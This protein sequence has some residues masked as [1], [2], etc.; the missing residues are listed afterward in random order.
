[1]DGWK[2]PEGY[3]ILTVRFVSQ[4]IRFG[5]RPDMGEWIEIE[6]LGKDA[7]ESPGSLD[8]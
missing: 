4:S 7:G 1:M 3:G 5:S 6:P 2:V 8:H